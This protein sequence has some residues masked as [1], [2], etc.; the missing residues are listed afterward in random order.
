MSMS[1]TKLA[2]YPGCAGA[3][4]AIDQDISTKAVFEQLGIELIEMEGWNCC[5]AAEAEDPNMVY[6]LNARN[7]VIAEKEGLNVATPCSICFYNLART[8]KALKE[9]ENLRKRMR[10]IDSSLDYKGTISAKHTLDI[11]VNEVGLDEVGKKIK[12]KVAVKVAPY[13][14]CYL[15]RPSEIGFDNPE[16][17]DSMDKIVELA[18]G[19]PISFRQMRIRCCGGPL[20]MTRGDLAFE[21]SKRVLEA[22]KKEGADC[23]IT[24]CPLCHMML[25]AKQPDIE[26]FFNITIGM[27]VLYFSQLLGLALGV[28]PKKLA[29]NKNIV[30]TKE[31]EEKVI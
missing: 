30:S 24:A 26:E 22:A 25:D 17:P 5:G 9:D 12:K 31:I 3:T 7:L 4:H 8:D 2:Y 11:L 29:L 16:M 15:E 10:D 13:Y 27:P 23:I 18:G 1:V 6:A 28:E 14:G 21:L 20:M 19:M